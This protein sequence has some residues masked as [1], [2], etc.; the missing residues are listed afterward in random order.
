MEYFHLVQEIAIEGFL[1][2]SVEVDDHADHIEFQEHT[3]EHF[4]GVAFARD[5]PSVDV[6]Q[7]AC[8]CFQKFDS[9]DILEQAKVRC[10]RGDTKG[11][12]GT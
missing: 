10:D 11:A 4:H 2:I 3:A 1:C 9:T 12:T 5:A 6:L 7:Q 8:D